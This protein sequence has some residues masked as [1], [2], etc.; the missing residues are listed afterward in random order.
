VIVGEETSGHV[1]GAST[2][3]FTTTGSP[4]TQLPAIVDAPGATEEE[5]EFTNDGRYLGFVRIVSGRN[6]LFV[7]DTQTQLLVNNA[8]V[9]VGPANAEVDGSVALTNSTSVIQSSAIVASGAINL[10][11]VSSSAIGI[12]VQ[13]VVGRT[14]VLGHSA[15]KLTF[16]GRVP[17]GNFTSGSRHVHWNRRVNGRPLAPGE[18]QVTVRALTPQRAVRELGK[19]MLIRIVVAHR[20]R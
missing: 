11:L 8:G 6:R 5:P 1:G 4:I 14:T 16:V 3:F 17:L 20:H 13:K 12:I 15:P 19:P 7:W 10:H 2:L 18:Y 9:D